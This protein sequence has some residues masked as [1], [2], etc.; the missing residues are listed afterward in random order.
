MTSFND[1]TFT[2]TKKCKLIAR[3]ISITLRKLSIWS[4]D[5]LVLNWYYS[6]LYTCYHS[7]TVGRVVFGGKTELDWMTPAI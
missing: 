6:A 2:I 3:T 7:F 4:Y 5:K 1:Q